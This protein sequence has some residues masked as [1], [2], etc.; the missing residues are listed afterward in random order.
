[1]L[2][3]PSGHRFP[4]LP[5]AG[6]DNWKTLICRG[7]DSG[8]HVSRHRGC[9]KFGKSVARDKIKTAYEALLQELAP[10]QA[11]HDLMLTLFKKRWDQSQVH[12]REAQKALKQEV[13]AIEKKIEATLD[14]MLN[15][16]SRS[17]IG[18]FERKVEELERKK[19]VLAERTARCGREAKGFDET[20]RTAFDLIS[21]PWNLWKNG[22]LED[23]RI[24]LKLPL[25]EQFEYDWNDGVRTAELSMPFKVLLGNCDYK[26]ELADREGFEPS[27]GLH[28][29]TR[30]RRAP[31]TTRPP[32]R[33]KARV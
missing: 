29:Y 14:L 2:R 5:S 25:A 10:S 11:L 21:N 33:S 24:V 23:K 9:E 31:S 13:T 18:A 4:L 27:M 7:P 12:T 30:S 17:V 8:G 26:N 3:R 6:P 1:M 32:A 22:Q 15:S 20:F 28:P 16:E 19:L